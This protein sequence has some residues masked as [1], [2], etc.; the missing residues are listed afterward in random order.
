MTSIKRTAF[1]SYN[2]KGLDL[3]RALWTTKFTGAKATKACTRHQHPGLE[4]EDF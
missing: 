3:M 2:S 1:Y 4:S